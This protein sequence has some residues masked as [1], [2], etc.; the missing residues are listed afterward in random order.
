MF[1]L[2]PRQLGPTHSRGLHGCMVNVPPRVLLFGVVMSSVCRTQRP[3]FFCEIILQQTLLFHARLQSWDKQCLFI[4]SA[5]HVSL[6]NATS[7]RMPEVSKQQEQGIRIKFR[8]GSFDRRGRTR[9]DVIP[10]DRLKFALTA[11]AKLLA[12]VYCKLGKNSGNVLP[13]FGEHAG[14]ILS[15]CSFFAPT[16]L[17]SGPC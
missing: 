1:H 6:D 7:A 15:A 16:R 13:F 12:L 5:F 14:G 3:Y 11:S 17:P 2:L 4:N 9:A 8:N 10:R